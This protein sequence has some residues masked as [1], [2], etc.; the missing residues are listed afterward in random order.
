MA[1]RSSKTVLLAWEIGEGFG[2]L[3]TL[4]AIA[5]ALKDEGWTVVFA[6]RDPI[7]TRASLVELNC[8]ILP[9][10]FW[11]NPVAVTKPTY[12]YAD[13][14]A[15]NG[16]SSA[17]D[18]GGL[19][20]AWD[21]LFAVA[22]PDLLICEHAPGAALAA[23]GRLPVAF[24]G[25]G[26]VVPPADGTIFEPYKPVSGEPG[27]QAAILAAM[28]QALALRGRTPPKTVTEPFRGAFRAVYGF[29]ELD[30]YRAIRKDEVLGPLEFLPP[31][32]P[33]PSK[34]RL[35]A[36]SANDYV[37]IDELS[38]ALMELG[39]QASVYL[40]GTLGARG[41]VLRS[42]GVT[43]Y[44]EAPSL[45]EMLPL[46]TCVF[47]HAGSGL[48]AAA[49][50]AGRPQILSPRHGEA[51]RTAKLLEDLGVGISIMPLERKRLREAI[52]CLN[53]D[54]KFQIAARLAGE[55]AHEFVEKRDAVGRTV[56]A[57]DAAVK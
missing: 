23:F 6:L 40:R 26:F 37:L 41:N 8:A 2:H 10:P 33:I 57:L 32:T 21:D 27:S 55:T 30:P 31:L 15:A 45:R 28:Q 7:Q 39:P 36:Y 54:Q 44:G 3:P 42:R 43:V 12:T 19:I 1:V 14:L 50:A 35:F 56:A 11:P 13:I 46:A 38:A 17:Q 51:D 22:K 25:N 4:K 29:P 49:L 47:S 18:V 34:P 52:E 16:F 5:A 53:T 24:V 48:T 9:S 20:G